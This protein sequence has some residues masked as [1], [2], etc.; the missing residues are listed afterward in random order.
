MKKN[1]LLQNKKL[2]T[3]VFLLFTLI[4]NSQTTKISN[5]AGNYNITV[6]AGVSSFTIE[7]YGGGGGGGSSN[8]SNN[9]GGSG[10]GSGAY[11]KGIHSVTPGSTYYFTVGTGGSGGPANSITPPTAGTSSWFNASPTN[12]AAPAN[13]SIG[14]LAV[15][16]SSE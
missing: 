3:L 9:N 2:A 7:A 11:A 14:T 10:G 8:N 4:C 15:F 13:N 16:I 12:N 1:I 5:T 6:P